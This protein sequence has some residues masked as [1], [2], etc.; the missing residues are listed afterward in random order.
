MNNSNRLL[1]VKVMFNVL[2]S[3]S[4][5]NNKCTVPRLHC[6][7]ACC[8]RWDDLIIGQTCVTLLCFYSSCGLLCLLCTCKFLFPLKEKVIS[9]FLT[10]VNRIVLDCLNNERASDSTQRRAMLTF[11]P[12]TRTMQISVIL[13]SEVI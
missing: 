9:L 13:R 1:I 10:S 8:C 2:Y 4:C 3:W 5:G 11:D 6:S 12:S 7:A